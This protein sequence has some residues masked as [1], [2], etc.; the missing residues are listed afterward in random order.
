MAYAPR[1]APRIKWARIWQEQSMNLNT[2]ALLSNTPSPDKLA[3]LV[4]PEMSWK[5]F[6]PHSI[7]YQHVD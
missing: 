5:M 7:M 3:E 2:I 1:T 4:M 6:A